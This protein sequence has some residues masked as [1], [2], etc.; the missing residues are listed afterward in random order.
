MRKLTFFLS[1]LAATCAYA[2]D[3]ACSQ[4]Q[5]VEAKSACLDSLMR[6]Q[7]YCVSILDTDSKNLCM[8]QVRQQ[9]S[10]C[11]SIRSSDIKTICFD[12]FK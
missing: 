6:Q 1:L 10:Y 5:T 3:T 4:A 9:K 8:A 11:F 2:Q 12:V 7:S